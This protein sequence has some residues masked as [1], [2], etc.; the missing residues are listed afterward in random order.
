MTTPNAGAHGHDPRRSNSAAPRTP[1]TPEQRRL[2]AQ[3]AAHVSHANSDPHERTAAARAA[4]PQGRSYW[5]RKVR[6]DHPDL[7][8]AEVARRAEHLHKAHMKR[9]ALKSS[10]TRAARKTAAE[11][12]GAP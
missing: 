1:L 3:I 11:Q 4:T 9:L 10:K 8:D 12:D 6:E 7:D 2:R 5:E